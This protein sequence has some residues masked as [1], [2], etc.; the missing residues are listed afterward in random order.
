MKRLI[1]LCLYGHLFLGMCWPQS[2]S[3]VLE[4]YLNQYIDDLPT[5]N[6]DDFDPPSQA[7]LLSWENVIK[8]MLSNELAMARTIADSLNYQLIEFQDTL[9]H[10]AG[11][12]YLLEEKNPPKHF[13]GTY[14]I[15]SD[16]CRADLVLQAPHPKFDTNTGKEAVYA[17][18]RLSARALMLSGTHRCNHSDQSSCDGSTSVCNSGSGP[19]RISDMAHNELTAFHTT[20]QAIATLIPTSNFIQLHGFAKQSTD[21][22]VI[23]S[24][25]T[26]DTP[27]TDYASLLKTEL[28]VQDPVLSFKIAHIDQ[29]WTRLIGFTNTQGRYLNGSDS[30]CDTGAGSTSGRFIHVEQEKGRLRE[31][32]SGWKKMYEA[33]S[34]VFV[35]DPS[36]SIQEDLSQTDVQVYPNPSLDRNLWIKGTNIQGIALLDVRGKSWI[37]HKF[38]GTNLYQLKV[39]ELPPGIY[40]I[41]LTMG[42]R[43]IQKRIILM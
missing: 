24:N 22:Y 37:R 27:Q 33:V 23:L 38:Q 35:C 41:Q 3:G 39:R 31:D 21:P 7:E 2:M 8:K 11:I 13:W 19:Y 30:P 6:G 1:L 20:T 40:L 34:N 17:F 29:S 15:H 10:S 42:G 18:V 14:V 32:A 9:P 12:Y 4:S 5:S 36:T 28:S 43:I 26:R 25:G 16:P